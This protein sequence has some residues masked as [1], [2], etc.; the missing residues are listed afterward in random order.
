MSGADSQA[1]K[2]IE[3]AIRME[4]VYENMEHAMEYSVSD[5]SSLASALTRSRSPL[6]MSPCCISTSRSMDTLSKLS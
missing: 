2:K 5:A 1:Q 4:R 6:A 3:E